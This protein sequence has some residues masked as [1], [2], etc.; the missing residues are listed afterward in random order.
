MAMVKPTF[1]QTVKALEQQ[2]AKATS[3]DAKMDLCLKI[4]KYYSIRDVNLGADYA[5]KAY[6]Y[7]TELQD[8]DMMAESS[9]VNAECFLKKHDNSGALIRFRRSLKHAQ[10]A[11]NT[12]RA[13][14][15]FEQIAKISLQDRNMK[16]LF[17]NNQDV[18][19]Y[20]KTKGGGDNSSGGDDK[21]FLQQRAR[22]AREKED[23]ER[24]KKSLEREISALTRDRDRISSDKDQLNAKQKELI[25]QKGDF[26]KEAYEKLSTAERQKLEKEQ[27]A[28]KQSKE[29]SSLRKK[30]K[31]ISD[32]LSEQKEE[33]E[34]TNVELANSQLKLNRS[35]YFRNILLL[36][37]G[38]VLA[39]AGLFYNRYR[40]K[41][42]SSLEL[43]NK[44]KII[45]EERKR[46]DDLLLNILPA[47]IAQELKQNGSAKAHRYDEVSVL[48]TDFKNFTKV[49][50]KLT[51]EELVTELDT[52]F[53]A[54][55]FIISQYNI[56]KIKTIGDSYMCA[57]GLNNL[58]D[59]PTNM[60]Q[61][62]LK[63]Q[64]FLND[65]KQQKILRGEPYFEARI[66]IHTGP[67]VA[68]VVG[69]KKFAY[70]IWGDTVN[71]AARMEQ[72]SEEGHVNISETT[73]WK[74]KYDFDCTYRGKISAKNKGDI[75]MYYVNAALKPEYA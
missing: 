46:S 37:S 48:F 66:G 51:P 74:V 70:D 44:N 31:L 29:I 12:A 35:K 1:A 52:C 6:N 64:E 61:A 27:L 57:S 5:H 11:G 38:F 54:F 32:E 16:D 13:A 65:V 41:K 63:M 34:F 24:E 71:I 59:S 4:A 69:S 2:L 30:S 21:R 75:D 19:S 73:Y 40:S 7:A 28:S 22:L 17:Q 50:E 55:D 72:N 49:S 3:T 26:E 20:L 47:N 25:K 43:E 18:V 45:E 68:G 42:K 62:A 23:L 15:C 56:E 14:A 60:I 33:L 36:L 9:Y 53:K 58:G 10:D 8:D 39:L 67:V